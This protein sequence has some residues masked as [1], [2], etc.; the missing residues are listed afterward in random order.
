MDCPSRSNPRIYEYL[1]IVR[2]IEQNPIPLININGILSAINATLRIRINDWNR[3][4]ARIREALLRCLEPTETIKVYS[5]RENTATRLHEEYDQVLDIEYIRTD[6]QFHVLRKEKE[7]PM[8]DHVNQFI[9]ISKMSNI[10]N[11]L[12]QLKD[13][14]TINL[15][16]VASVGED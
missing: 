15:A 6:I 9:E 3:H 8:N 12:M 5:V 7:T 14:E 2:G 13:K 1:D 4:Y 11:L 10:I 16:F